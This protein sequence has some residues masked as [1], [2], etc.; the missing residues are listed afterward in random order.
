MWRMRCESEVSVL[1]EIE[2][3]RNHLWNLEEVLVGH[4]QLEVVMEVTRHME[5]VGVTAAHD[6]MG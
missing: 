3:G 1:G 6:V 5:V 4:L 2:R